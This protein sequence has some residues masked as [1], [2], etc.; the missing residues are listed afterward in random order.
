MDM[1]FPITI[2]VTKMS[3]YINTVIGFVKRTW[4]CSK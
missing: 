1:T 4:K 2:I 3:T